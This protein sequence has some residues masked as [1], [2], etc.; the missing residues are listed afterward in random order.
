[1][2]IEEFPRHKLS[3]AGG[4]RVFPARH[5]MQKLTLTVSVSVGV[6]GLPEVRGVPDLPV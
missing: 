3:E 6:S 1:M 4:R 2:D 5:L